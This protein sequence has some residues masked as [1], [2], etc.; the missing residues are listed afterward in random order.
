MYSNAENFF[1]VWEVWG[2]SLEKLVD[3][4]PKFSENPPSPANSESTEL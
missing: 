3:L 2:F 4:E 1:S